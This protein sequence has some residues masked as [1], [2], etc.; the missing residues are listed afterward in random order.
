MNTYYLLILCA[1][2]SC[3][4][5]RYGCEQ[6]DTG[7]LPDTLGPVELPDI[8][9]LGPTEK[10]LNNQINSYTLMIISTAKKD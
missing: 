1:R 8:N 3:N 7:C 5:N 10:Q 6:I 9:I 2:Y 4:T